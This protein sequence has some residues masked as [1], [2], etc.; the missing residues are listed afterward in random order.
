M[1][2]GDCRFE[3]GRGANRTKVG[4]KQK[5]SD[6][7]IHILTSANRTKVGLKL[8]NGAGETIA[9]GCANR[10]KVGLKRVGLQIG[11]DDLPVL[12]EPRWD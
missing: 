10:T 8:P 6:Q 12:I 3:G 7:L 5:Y 2:F 4:L 9:T 11:A 1:D